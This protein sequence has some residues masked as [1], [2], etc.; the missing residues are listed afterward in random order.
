M[1][2]SSSWVGAPCFEISDFYAT[3]KN[4]IYVDKWF[5]TADFMKILYLGTT[6]IIQIGA[7]LAHAVL[8]VQANHGSLVRSFMAPVFQ[9]GLKFKL[10]LVSMTKFSGTDKEGI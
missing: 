9:M 5:H 4:D 8:A 3:C 10:G 1:Q 7:A 2:T 6:F